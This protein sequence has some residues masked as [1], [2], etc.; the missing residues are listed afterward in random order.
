MQRVPG[1]LASSPAKG[2]G[3]TTGG[4]CCCAGWTW[5][6]AGSEALLSL[7]VNRLCPSTSRVS[8]GGVCVCFAH[9][10]ASCRAAWCP[11]WDDRGPQGGQ[12]AP[13]AGPCAPPLRRCLASPP[14][15]PWPGSRRGAV[16]RAW[17]AWPTRPARRQATW[18]GSWSALC[19]KRQQMCTAR[20]SRP[21][22]RSAGCTACRAASRACRS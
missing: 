10:G 11:R 20:S 19:A 22:A 6:C 1:G 13:D 14:V 18:P 7:T 4:P 5:S 2:G 8:A 16:T 15:Q 9:A 21:A 17:T 3:H 12:G